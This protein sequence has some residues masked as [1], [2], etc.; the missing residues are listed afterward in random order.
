MPSA[1]WCE[2][3]HEMLESASTE[4][5]E[6][7]RFI[8]EAVPDNEN[9]L[10]DNK[11][12]LFIHTDKTDKGKERKF[13]FLRHVSALANTRDE[14][15]YRYLFICFTDDGTF[16]GESYWDA[17][18]GDH[19]ADLDDSEVQNVFSDSLEPRPTVQIYT[20]E[21]D[22]SHGIV[23]EIEREDSPPILFDESITVDNGNTTKV[24]PGVGYVRK[25]SQSQRMTNSDYQV[26]IR[27]RESIVNQTIENAIEG[28]NQIVGIPSSQ[29]ENID[30]SVSSSDEGVPID[31]IVTTEG[32]S[33][34][35]KRLSLSVKEW[36]TSEELYSNRDVIYTM[37]K[38][39]REL[40][41]DNEKCKFLSYSSLNNY[42]PP[43]QWIQEYDN[44]LSDLMEGFYNNH[45]NGNIVTVFESTNYI[46]ENKS[47]FEKLVSDGDYTYTSSDAQEYLRNIDKNPVNKVEEVTSRSNV[48]I[49]GQDYSIVNLVESGGPLE[50]GMEQT[51]DSLLKN[52]EAN[53]R[54]ILRDIEYA[55]LARQV[56]L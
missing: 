50:T 30:L 31:E 32:Y 23:L 35:N 21:Q 4:D 41:L 52:D 40:Q 37:L 22:D 6:I 42:I 12:Q 14:Q 20:V 10:Y 36:N 54:G 7:I 16:I 3:L 17:D 48:Q 45:M 46:L 1:H 34:L 43:S 28:L 24:K 11:R 27:R 19:I 13:D 55:R 47:V 51:V 26:I 25:G 56:T 49:G 15:R 38:R 18:G 53:N 8:D 29:L 39:R 5:S 2:A 33:D 44:N 9:R